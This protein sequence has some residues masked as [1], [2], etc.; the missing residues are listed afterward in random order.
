MNRPQEITQGFYCAWNA[1]ET[2]SNTNPE[3]S[4]HNGFQVTG[5]PVQGS[6]IPQAL[7]MDD[8]R[9][10]ASQNLLT[11]DEAFL[12]EDLPDE[13][14]I[15]SPEYRPM[16]DYKV[17]VDYAL[18]EARKEL[19][20]KKPKVMANLGTA[21]I[22]SGVVGGG[23]MVSSV[24]GGVCGLGMI[25][26]AG[27]YV[28]S[29][30]ISRFATVLWEGPAG[31]CFDQLQ[32]QVVGRDLLNTELLRHEQELSTSCEDIREHDPDYTMRAENDDEL[33]QS[34]QAHAQVTKE[35]LQAEIDIRAGNPYQTGIAFVGN[36]D[37]RISQAINPD[38]VGSRVVVNHRKRAWMAQNN[39]DSVLSPKQ[40]KRKK[41]AKKV[42]RRGVVYQRRDA[43]KHHKR[44]VRNA[45]QLEKDQK[46]N[47]T[48]IGRLALDYQWLRN[49]KT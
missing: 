38:T 27:A 28:A 34:Q 19:E 6:F 37:H 43:L 41:R 29:P 39:P 35:Q 45:V 31:F 4:N 2:S 36:Y 24:L 20:R 12:D 49:R 5:A 9:P 22:I 46:F 1:P 23:F 14:N 26:C 7:P 17:T 11:A 33:N 18:D 25:A 44:I 30:A 40:L 32:R 15:N 48:V 3:S 13:Y 47:N 21:I 10:F 42:L 16:S 8:P